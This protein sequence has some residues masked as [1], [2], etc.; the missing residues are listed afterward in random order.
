M[1]IKSIFFFLMIKQI[2]TEIKFLE[3]IFLVDFFPI[4]NILQTN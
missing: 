2:T 1:V 3:F 4:Y